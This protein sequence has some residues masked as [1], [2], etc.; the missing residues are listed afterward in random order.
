MP[1]VD[2]V[3]TPSATAPNGFVI[4]STNVLNQKNGM[5][6]YSLNGRSAVP[7]QGGLLCVH[8]P[9]RRTINVSSNG[10]A[11]PANNCTGIYALDFNSFARGAYSVIP[12]PELSVAGT[13]IDAQWWGRDP[14]FAAPNN[15]SLSRG[16]EFVMCY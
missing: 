13:V 16:L 10:S 2:W 9:I 12:P 7:F 6:I 15:T 14:G 4:R 11:L 3:G 1:V 8:A 5:L